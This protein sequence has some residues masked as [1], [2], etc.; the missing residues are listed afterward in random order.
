[1][2]KLCDQ[3][4]NEF[5]TKRNNGSRQRFCST[6]CARAEKWEKIPRFTWSKVLDKW[7]YDEE[8]RAIVSREGPVSRMHSLS[9]A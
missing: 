9:I 3:C 2:K 1:M 4:H 7:I 5:T 8:I 6:E